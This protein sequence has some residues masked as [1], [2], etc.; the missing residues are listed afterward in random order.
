[1]IEDFADTET[2]RLWQTGTSRRFP[3]T[4]HRP[5]LRKLLLIDQAQAI[6]DLASPPGNRLK[7]LEG[8]RKTDWSLRVNDQWRITFQWDGQHPH[9]VAIEDYH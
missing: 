8:R 9:H 6:G 2:A 1:V 3:Q 5:M 4:L 7:R